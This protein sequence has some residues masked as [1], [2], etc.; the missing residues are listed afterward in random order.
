MSKLE[1]YQARAAESLAAVDAATN[2]RDRAFHHR[3][4]AIYR[5]LIINAG[6]AESHST[7]ATPKLTGAAPRRTS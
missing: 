5:R 3:A 2:A 6:E 7:T 4:H 1:E